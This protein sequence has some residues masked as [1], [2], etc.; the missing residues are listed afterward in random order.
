MRKY[1]ASQENAK[2]RKIQ[3]A[4]AYALGAF[5]ALG[6]LGAAENHSRLEGDVSVIVLGFAVFW[7][8]VA[9]FMIRRRRN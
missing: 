3:L 4:A 6:L 2:S 7:V 5:S 8:L 9:R 1:A